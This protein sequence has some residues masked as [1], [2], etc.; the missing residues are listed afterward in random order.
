MA[1]PPVAAVYW[2]VPTVIVGLVLEVLVPSVRL[3]AVR[4]C[5]PLVPKM[6]PTVCVPATSTALVGNV[7]SESLEVMPTRSL[8]VLTRFQLASTPLTVTLNATARFCPMGVPVLPVA[9]PGAAVS[10]GTSN[11]NLANAPTATVTFALTLAVSTP[12]ASVAVIVRVPAV[13]NVKDDKARVPETSVRLPA[14]APLS[15]L[16]TALPSELV[17]VMLVVAV[18]T[19]FQLASTA[20]TTTELTSAAPAV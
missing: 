19:T 5:E 7:A 20:L 13:L 11:C 2:A 10:P 15:S 16:I 17:M 12:P 3:V 18:L 8:A 14:V 9:L 6:T 4:V 1:L